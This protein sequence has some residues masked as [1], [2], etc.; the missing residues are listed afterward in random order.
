MTRATT[1][2]RIDAKVINKTLARFESIEVVVIVYGS[3]DNAIASSR[4]FIPSLLSRAEANVVF[5]WPKAFEEAVT[6]IEIIPKI[7][8]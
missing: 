6:K 1:T 3:N 5:T 4:T 8:F 2:P 7:Q